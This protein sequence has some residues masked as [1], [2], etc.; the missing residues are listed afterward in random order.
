MHS[1]SLSECNLHIASAGRIMILQIRDILL[2]FCFGITRKNGISREWDGYC[3]AAL[4]DD[5]F[6]LHAI[7]FVISSVT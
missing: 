5:L 2:M 6:S 1:Q 7:S 3:A 4:V